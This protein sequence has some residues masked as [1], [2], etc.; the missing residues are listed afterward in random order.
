MLQS[1]FVLDFFLTKYK[2]IELH[3]NLKGLSM[4]FGKAKLLINRKSPRYG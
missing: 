4:L 2:H 1:K 3:K